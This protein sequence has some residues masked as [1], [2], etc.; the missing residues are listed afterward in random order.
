MSNRA[1]LYL[2]FA[3]ARALITGLLLMIMGHDRVDLLY[4]YVSDPLSYEWWVVIWLL[5][6]VWLMCAAVVKSPHMA[7]WGLIAIVT[8]TAVWAVGVTASFA[9]NP[10]VATVSIILWWTLVAKDLIQ[11]RQPMSS[12][13]EDLVKQYGIE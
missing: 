7:A 8:T 6:G 11:I 5:I 2:T 3:G 9:T 12:P 1:R 4:P 10:A 13:F